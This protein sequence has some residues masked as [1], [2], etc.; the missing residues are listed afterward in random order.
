MQSR[1]S[2][3]F[4][5]RVVVVLAV[6]LPPLWLTLL[7]T[8]REQEAFA[9]VRGCA[10]R[11]LRALGC[12]VELQTA[13]GVRDDDVVMFVSNHVSIADAAVLLAVLPF[14]LRFVANHIFA[15]YPLIGPAIR[16]ASANIVNR[17]SWRSRADS[18]QAMVDALARGQS[19]LVFPEGTTADSGGMLPFRSGAFRAAARTGR[20]VVPIALDGTRAMMPAGRWLLANVPIRIRVL[21]PIAPE[22]TGRDA[23]ASLRDASAA[24]IAAWLEEIRR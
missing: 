9:R 21:D 11:V 17:G 19:L 12:Q 10:R 22:G 1:G 15:E 20:R 18:G 13:A 2:L 16:G 23:V 14:D 3:L 4:T 24:A 6:L 8:R 5:V 7:F